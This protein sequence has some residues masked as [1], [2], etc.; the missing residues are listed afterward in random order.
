MSWLYLSKPMDASAAKR[1]FPWRTLSEPTA[2]E[3]IFM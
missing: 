3:K 1:E 2:V